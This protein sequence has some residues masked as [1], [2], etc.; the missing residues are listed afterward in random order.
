[1]MISRTWVAH[2]IYGPGKRPR[3]THLRFENSGGVL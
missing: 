3:V 1:M 2:I